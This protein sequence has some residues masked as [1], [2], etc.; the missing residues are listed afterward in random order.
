MFLFFTDWQQTH[1]EVCQLVALNSSTQLTENMLQCVVNLAKVVLI[2]RN[3]FASE[4]I[5]WCVVGS[6]KLCQFGYCAQLH[7]K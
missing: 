6:H 3:I 7:I 5:V 1:K 4:A 2:K